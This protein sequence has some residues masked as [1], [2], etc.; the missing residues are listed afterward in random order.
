MNK[1]SRNKG[2]RT[3]IFGGQHNYHHDGANDN[4]QKGREVSRVLCS[5]SRL[6]SK[7]ITDTG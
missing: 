4:T 2:D 1:N 6:K 7:L 3:H 5:Y